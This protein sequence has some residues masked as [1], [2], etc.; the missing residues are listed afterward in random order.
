VEFLKN[1]KRVENRAFV[2]AE[3]R[4]A[5]AVKGSGYVFAPSVKK[6]FLTRF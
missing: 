1:G 2:F 6:P 3:R 5:I 4:D